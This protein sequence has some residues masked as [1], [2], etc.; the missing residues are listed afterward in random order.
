MR[1]CSDGSASKYHHAKA[2][3]RALIAEPAA[4]AVPLVWS[5]TN[6]RKP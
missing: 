6:R 3:E 4:F 2:T 5:I 1:G